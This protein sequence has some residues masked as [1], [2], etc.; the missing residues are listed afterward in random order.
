MCGLLDILTV[1]VHACYTMSA[2]LSLS[3][4]SQLN[5]A[6]LALF[7]HLQYRYVMSPKTRMFNV[8]DS[9]PSVFGQS[10]VARQ[11]GR[12]SYELTLCL[13][14]LL[15]MSSPVSMICFI[16]SDSLMLWWAL[17]PGKVFIRSVEISGKPCVWYSLCR[18]CRLVPY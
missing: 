10:V 8:T 6:I 2:T 15:G 14:S 16:S 13:A 9:M 3:T 11:Y 4:D 18:C 12:H 5:I 17:F 7:C 1:L